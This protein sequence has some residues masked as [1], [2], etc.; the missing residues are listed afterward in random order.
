MSVYIFLAKIHDALSELGLWMGMVALGAVATLTFVGTLSRYFFDAPIGWVSDWT[1]YL[2]AMTIFV[3]AP[4]VT[5]RCMHVSMDL[6]TSIVKSQRI[7]CTITTTALALTFS[8]LAT[9]SW[10]VWESLVSDFF[11]GTGTAAGYPIPRWWLLCFV[12]YG[13]ASSGLYT[14]RAGF[15]SLFNARAAGAV[16][17]PG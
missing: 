13:F 10:V 15:A 14:L 3:A 11:S 7:N 1:G 9:M 8:I 2:L 5:K 16:E 17:R 12:F 4:A 6:L